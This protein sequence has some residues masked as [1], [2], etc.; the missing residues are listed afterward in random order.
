MTIN[1]K[2]AS[3]F[4][5]DKGTGTPVVMLHG[6]LENHTMWR[7]IED[8]LSQQ[9][10]VICIDLLGHGN[11]DCMGYI[12]T[13]D[14]MAL[15]VQAVL[16][17]LD[18]T[19]V[20]LVGHSMGGYVGLAFAK[21][22]P[23]RT[24]SLCLLNSTPL[25]DDNERAALRTRANKMAKTQ[26]EQ[27]VRMSFTNLF[28]PKTKANHLNQISEALDHALKTP[29]QGYI[30]A[31]S[32]MQTREDLSVFFKKASFMRAMIL[33]TT[34]WIIDAQTQE[35]KFKKDI[36][37]FKMIADGHMSHISQTNEVINLLKEFIALCESKDRSS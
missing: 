12:H 3:I 34:D 22:Q 20:H 23:A 18:V 5:T 31:N 28:D 33:G 27:L 4:Y 9:Y 14:A 19:K 7:A 6:F 32:G 2:D 24:A 8:V 21:A 10:R 11:T 29:V 15:A 30:A 35:N 25:P 26:Y 37:F 36:D 1:H 17:T 13:M 16:D